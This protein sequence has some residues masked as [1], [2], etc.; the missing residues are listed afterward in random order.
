MLKENNRES[1]LQQWLHQFWQVVVVFEELETTFALA[2]RT[3]NICSLLHFSPFILISSYKH[4]L[5]EM[6]GCHY[7]S[8]VLARLK[9]LGVAIQDTAYREVLTFFSPSKAKNLKK[10]S[11][12]IHFKG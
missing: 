11:N 9:L 5:R 1:D 10:L 12:Y 7:N 2:G 6:Q 4:S 8:Q 3:A